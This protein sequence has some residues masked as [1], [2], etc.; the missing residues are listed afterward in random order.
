MPGKGWHPRAEYLTALQLWWVTFWSTKDSMKAGQHSV[1]AWQLESLLK[2]LK[3]I[4]DDD[5]TK[6]LPGTP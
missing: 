3:E 2:Q 4:D 6:E 5:E 1:V